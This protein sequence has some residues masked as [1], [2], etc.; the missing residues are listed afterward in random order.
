[1]NAGAREISV[2]GEAD[3]EDW[4]QFPR[5]RIHSTV[6]DRLISTVSD[7]T[8]SS[9][10]LDVRRL[11]TPS[12]LVLIGIVATFFAVRLPLMYRQ[13]GGQDEGCYAVPGLTILQS[14]I[15]RLPHVP[16]RNP[17][18]VYYR[19][20]DALFA[21]PP[22]TFYVQA[23]LYAVLPHQFGTARL[24]SALAGAMLL[25]LVYRLT[26]EA[27][28]N[29]RAALW[30][31]GLCSLSRWF[32]FPA[33]SAR[34]DIWC[35]LFGVA[36][37]W[38][39][40]TEQRRGQWTWMSAAGVCLGLGGL[41]HPFAILYAVQLAVWSAMTTRGWR[42]V[43]RPAGLAAVALLVAALWL[44]LMALFPEACRMQFRNQFGHTAESA[45]WYR[46]VMPWESLG[47][48][49]VVM[50]NHCGAWQFG[51]VGVG[52]LAASVAGYR[53]RSSAMQSVCWLAWSSIYLLSIVV[54][55]H[56]PVIGYWVYPAAL[57]FAAVGW[58]FDKV[59][60]GLGRC[61][62]LSWAQVPLALAVAA[63]MLP[64]SGLRAL[65]AHYRHWNEI[66]YNAPR[67]A[68]RLI[69]SL[70]PQVVCA[71]DTQFTLDFVAAGRPTL[72]AQTM[73]IYF[74]LDQFDYDVLIVS[75]EADDLGL[76]R[77]LGARLRR[78]EGFRHGIFACYAEVYDPPARTTE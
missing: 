41:S 46:A 11:C 61:A 52:L 33:T 59:L 3:D 25:G 6:S 58:C 28:G 13:P 56:H 70:P 1:V 37:V 16:A 72:W 20:D 44:P 7:R 10:L 18:S 26:K 77:Q 69:D 23:V 32:Y 57:M 36:A 35:A 48:H 51:L 76:A 78:R 8:T 73:P 45:L 15:P 74:R 65:A 49:A 5:R 68:R 21:E 54:G 39:V 71:V 22:F 53:Q 29:D 64:G 19:A 12:R 34:P 67:F 42:R 4:P 43:G 63:L 27:G 17:E 9:R 47:Y 24:A 55:R 62:R 50:W 38:C 75:R 66:E 30:A 60:Y 31:A 14:G 40:L 2:F